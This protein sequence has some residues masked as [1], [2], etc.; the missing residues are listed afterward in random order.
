M[1]EPVEFSAAAFGARRVGILLDA[2]VGLAGAADFLASVVD[3]LCRTAGARE[4]VFIMRTPPSLWSPRG[5]LVTASSL[6]KDILRRRR[7]SL[8]GRSID[9]Q[10]VLDQMV[11][12]GLPKLPLFV[13]GSSNEALAR[14]CEREGIDVVMP[15]PK[16]LI[17]Y[18]L[19]WVGYIFDFQHRYYRHFFNARAL[20]YRDRQFDDTLRHASTVIVNA[21]QVKVDAE[22][23][24]QPKALIVP[25][26]FSA[27]PG[28][29]WFKVDPVETAARYGVG[30]RY[31][32]ISNQFWVHKRHETAIAAFL[33]LAQ[34]HADIELV[35]T[36]STVDVRAPGH[37]P[38]LQAMIAQSG[39]AARI[40]ILGLIPKL[41]QI[42]L[43]R[44]AIA[45]I[46]PTA[47]EGGP[48]GGSVFDAVALGVQSI[49]SDLPVNR[50]IEEH[51]T[52]FFPLDDIDALAAAMGRVADLPRAEPIGSD[53]LI[54]RGD[55]RRAAMG[56]AL[57]DAAD[58]AMAAHAARSSSIRGRDRRRVET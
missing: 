33:R 18:R 39:L 56:R 50:E 45:V 23:F 4:V 5:L 32:I 38:M 30:R 1:T 22:H 44:G 35:C 17:G 46:Q 48:G 28:A 11:R 55:E 47:F 52:A 34:Q 49:V 36:G 25:L 8:P 41:D 57:W 10:T 14:L 42:A 3:G 7:P 24:H 54:R 21:R 19:P 40:H 13:V 9:P 29:E 31:F 15:T 20:R 53:I 37:F 12:D 27:A 2:F 16:A 6:A 51:V 43:L 58:H 26:P